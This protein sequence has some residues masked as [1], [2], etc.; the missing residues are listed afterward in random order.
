MTTTQQ[1]DANIKA[2]RSIS[3]IWFVPFIAM[4][5]GAWMV[6]YQWSHQGAIVT[7]HFSSAEGIEAGKTKIKFRNVN[8]GEVETIAL[9][10]SANGVI[11]TARM[12][13]NAEKTLVEDSQFWVVSPRV[14][15]AGISGL[16]T[17]ISGVYIEISPG[18][19][20]NESFEFKGLSEPPV[21]PQGTPGLHLTLNSDDQ[22][23][24][25][26]GDPIIYKGLKVGQFEDVFFN[27]DE[28]V[29]YYNVFIK[30]PYHQLITANTKFWNASGLSV[31]LTADG[32]AVNTGSLETMLTNGV[33]FNV[34]LGMPKG[35][36]VTERAY[37]DIYANYELASDERYKHSLQY[38]MLVSDT[39]RGLIVGAPVE[40]RGVLIGRV[41][42]TNLIDNE[43][44]E[45]F[46]EDIK[47][48]VLINLQPGRVGLPDDESGIALMDKQNKH[49]VKNGLKARLKTGNLL[50]GSLFVELQ[51]FDE[52]PV[53]VIETYAGY[54]VIPT[55]S[56]QFS[57]LTEKVGEFIDSLNQ[58]PLNDVV[59]SANGTLLE[60]TKLSQNLQAV[61]ENLELLLNDVNKQALAEQLRISLENIATLS[62]DFSS[63]SNG[64]QQLETT[65]KTFT[66][67]MH[68]L[69]PVLKQLKHQPNGLIFNP[70]IDEKILPTKHNEVQ[71]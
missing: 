58:L 7:I 56:D 44:N 20:S 10:E 14:S 29:V 40:Y 34:P 64:Y 43:T 4:L 53:N 71:P 52:Q 47:I 41:A 1:A 69:K 2:I 55:T 70:G 13:K 50:T 22:F 15:L 8:I 17:L 27:F 51:H 30:A 48:P 36:P 21:T 39:I 65:L 54:D 23:A 59:N 6:Y 61:S 42:S 33:T 12:L 16:N 63:G 57:Q 19:S 49:W 18:K 24:F 38:V 35:E 37:F 67:L 25:S 9:N 66:E 32:L 26:K 60:V 45:F 5:I 62:Q 68:E 11:V 28:R 31:E 3:I 46:N